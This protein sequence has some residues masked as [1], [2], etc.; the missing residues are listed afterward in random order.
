MQRVFFLFSKIVHVE[1]RGVPN[2]RS[3]RGRSGNCGKCCIRARFYNSIDDYRRR[4]KNREKE[5][6][7]DFRFISGSWF[8]RVFDEMEVK[9]L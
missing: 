8:R 2:V 3:E 5:T 7:L 1:E 4:K 6:H 9:N